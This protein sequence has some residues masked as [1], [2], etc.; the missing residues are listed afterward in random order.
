M[1]RKRMSTAEHDNLNTAACSRE[2]SLLGHVCIGLCLLQIYQ[3]WKCVFSAYH[4]QA[5]QN[6][7][8]D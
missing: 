7:L 4:L 5:Q 6:G 2:D 3:A 8:D 1:C